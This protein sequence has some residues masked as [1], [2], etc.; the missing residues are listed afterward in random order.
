MAILLC[1]SLLLTC[2]ACSKENGAFID[3]AVTRYSDDSL[4][5]FKSSDKALDRF[6]NDFSERHLRYNENSVGYFPIGNAVLF[7]KEWEAKSLMFFDTTSNNISDDRFEMMDNWLYN[8][9]VD[10]FGYVWQNLDTPSIPTEAPSS[11]F[12]QGWPW[13]DYNLSRGRST[14]WEFNSDGNSEGW[15]VTADGK[16]IVPSASNGMLSANVLKADTVEFISPEGFYIN[17]GSAPFL[18]MDIRAV[19]SEVLSDDGAIEDIE[20]YWQTDADASFTAKKMVSY[21]E[22]CTV[23]GTIPS[24]WSQLMYYPLFAHPQWGGDKLVNRLKIV[25]RTSETEDFSG[26]LGFN[27]IRSSMDS[28]TPFN[29]AWY[30]CAVAETFKYRGDEEMLRKTLPRLRAAMQ[31]SLS[32]MEGEKGLINNSMLIG[33]EG[34]LITDVGQDLGFGWADL[35]SYPKYDLLSNVYFYKSLTRMK[36]LE[37]MAVALEIEAEMPEVYARDNVTTVQYVQTPE[38]L[39]ALADTVKSNLRKPVD[40]QTQT[41]FFD[42]EKGRFIEGFNK[43]GDIV[44]YGY[45]QFNLELLKEGIA[46]TEQEKAVMDWISGARIVESDAQ[47]REQEYAV[48]KYGTARLDNGGFDIEG[49]FGIY[50]FEFAPRFS[51][52]KNYEQYAYIHKGDTAFGQ[53]VQDG[54]VSLHTSY[55]DIAVRSK[56]YGADNAFE[57]LKEIN[58]WYDKVS[59]YAQESGVGTDIESNYFY[60]AYY[61]E[62]G[63]TLQGDGVWA[64]VGLD[65]EFLESALLYVTV[66]DVFF[67]MG[68]DEA[69]TL[70]V[71]PRLP[72]SLSFWKM[73]NLLINGVMY[74]LTVS[75]SAVAFDRVLGNTDGLYVDVSLKK[76]SG[77]F[78]V[79]INGRKTS[80]FTQE[81]GYVTVKAPF[82]GCTIE[83]K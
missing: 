73:E 69:K 59:A 29:S 1:C 61:D 51:T 7:D 28:R 14:G 78:S 43:Y 67:G 24:N 75:D 56:V 15:A 3:A 18:Y 2:A 72:K 39:Q 49:T 71:K 35:L 50:D 9:P 77:K 34:G 80:S 63:V 47:G 33:H 48:G 55:Y 62:I 30:I 11:T 17:T 38:T 10:K 66:P 16:S 25:I 32:Y 83:V 20:I 82:K 22:W 60:H 4:L 19:Q 70:N 57:R 54:G 58:A 40:E 13:P 44:D 76:P 5:Y 31:F 64:G 37:E 45:I 36:Y 79:Y 23:T 81:N 68:S 46:T 27:F 52:V 42:E 21:K 53:Q 12:H 6:L 74:D 65:A 41:G 26:N 8:L